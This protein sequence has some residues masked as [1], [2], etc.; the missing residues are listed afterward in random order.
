VVDAIHDESVAF[1][2]LDVITVL[3][4]T[5]PTTL[6]EARWRKDFKKDLIEDYERAFK[7]Y[8]QKE[9]NKSEHIL[10]KLAK[11]G[12]KPSEVLLSRIP[13]ARKMEDWDGIWK[14]EEK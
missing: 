8:F 13:E 11:E 9:W 6:Y 14:W 1:R 12:D 2:C 5:N 10:K 7:Y 4:K 3:G